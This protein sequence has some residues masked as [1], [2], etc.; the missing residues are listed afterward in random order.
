M[1]DTNTI[2]NKLSN[3]ER[4]NEASILLY[5]AIAINDLVFEATAHKG[6]GLLE[7][8]LCGATDAVNRILNQA[9]DLIDGANHA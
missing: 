3:S 7:N 9:K 6:R 5:Q 8:T 1:T 4:L 2:R